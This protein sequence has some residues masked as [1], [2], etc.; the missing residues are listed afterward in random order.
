MH[1]MA[2]F[3]LA[4]LNAFT[5]A[6]ECHRDHMEDSRGEYASTAAKA[7]EAKD[8]DK[9]MSSTEDIDFTTRSVKMLNRYLDEVRK[10]RQIGADAMHRFQLNVQ[11]GDADSLHLILEQYVEMQYD[12]LQ[13]EIKSTLR[14]GTVG[15]G[16]VDLVEQDQ[17]LERVVEAS[18]LNGYFQNLR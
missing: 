18:Y 12:M 10:S 14:E 16:L 15:T 7:L 17:G 1:H 6:L 4:T 8:F 2:M 5:H 3:R 9:F 13:G 11:T